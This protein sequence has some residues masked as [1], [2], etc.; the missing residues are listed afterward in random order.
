MAANKVLGPVQI[1]SSWKQKKEKEEERKERQWK[2]FLLYTI[3]KY[4]N[5]YLIQVFLNKNKLKTF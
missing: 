4:L 2:W 3:L 1:P 5:E